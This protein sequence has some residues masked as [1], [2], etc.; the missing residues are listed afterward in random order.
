[1]KAALETIQET[2]HETFAFRQ[3]D[4]P[5]FTTPWHYHPEFEITLITSS[6]GE[7]FVGD[8]IWPFAEGEVYVFGGSLPHYFHNTEAVGSSPRARAQVIQF[9]PEIFGQCFW[10]LA[11]L[12]AIRRFIVRSQAGFKLRGQV[13]DA[14]ITRICRMQS[15]SGPGRLFEL[16]HLLNDLSLVENELESLSTEAFI[17]I[18]D[19]EAGQ[20]M[21]R[22][23]QYIFKELGSDLSLRGAALAAGMTESAFCRY[24]K[25][26]TG[27]RFTDMINELRVSRACRGLIETRQTIAETAYACGYG[28]L[29]NF[30]RCFKLTIGMAP[31][32]FRKRHA[33]L[34]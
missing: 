9:L 14:A 24:F 34:V 29:S 19:A 30:N 12:A 1:M 32:E 18:L 21:T 33:N 4:Q 10:D 15:Q 13:L 17:P 3:F 23:Y 27:K 8:R 20:R 31:S 26:M 5:R 2:Q 25:R 6:A 28:S 11:E 16:F 22:I 7:L